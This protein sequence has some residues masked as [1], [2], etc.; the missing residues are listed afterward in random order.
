MAQ[1]FV[2]I[3]INCD[4]H[5]VYTCMY[6]GKCVVCVN[7]GIHAG[8]VYVHMSMFVCMYVHMSYMHLDLT[9]TYT[10]KCMHTVQGQSNRS[11][12]SGKCLTTFHQVSTLYMP[13]N[14]KT[15]MLL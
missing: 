3:C 13:K 15:Y 1:S 5:C 7:L 9:Q 6:Y 2:I 4:P 14:I 11:G 8:V 10:H 12:Q